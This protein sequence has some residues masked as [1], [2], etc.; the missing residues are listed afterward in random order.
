MISPDVSKSRMPYASSH[1]RRLRV[2]WGRVAKS[3]VRLLK[4]IIDEHST[5]VVPSWFFLDAP[6]VFEAV[7]GATDPIFGEPVDFEKALSKN[8]PFRCWYSHGNSCYHSVDENV[9]T[10]LDMIKEV[11]PD[12]IICF[13]QASNCI[14]MALDA[15]RRKGVA[16][17]WKVTVMF[18]GGHIDDPIFDW[19]G[20]TSHHPTLRVFNAAKDTFFDGGEGSLQH[21]YPEIVEFPHSDG[22]MFPHSEPRAS[23]IYN[24]VAD[25]IYARCGKKWKN[26]WNRQMKKDN[27][28]QWKVEGRVHW[29]CKNAVICLSPVAF[30]VS[31]AVSFTKAPGVT[32][33][34]CVA[35][36][37]LRWK[38]SCG[39]PWM[40]FGCSWILAFWSE[41]LI[42]LFPKSSG[43]ENLN[44]PL[45][46]SDSCSA[47]VPQS[48]IIS[49]SHFHTLNSPT[50]ILNFIR[51]LNNLENLNNLKNLIENLNM[52]ED[53]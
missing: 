20:W 43:K 11:A 36:K 14:S 39:F 53:V 26:T 46:R 35:K 3:Q 45:S 28:F 8:Q 44:F 51:G 1:T 38:V 34:R 6:M 10:L 41:L 25:E 32:I 33:R 30:T 16:V 5:N 15:L 50:S 47:V 23:E 21:M 13:S 17:P 18:S 49:N 24:Q 37:D 31:F 12:V 2:D 4:K 22:H 42:A 27:F 7:A 40:L 9:E 19:Q 52:F 29:T 48:Q